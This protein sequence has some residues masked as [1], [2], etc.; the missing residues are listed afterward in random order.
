MNH[1]LL[2]LLFQFVL[3]PISWWLGAFFVIGY[4]LGREMAQAE[5]R[6]ISDF[7]GGKRANMPWWGSFEPRAWTEKGLL[8]WILPSVAVIACAF[9]AEYILLP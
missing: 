5:Y 7:Y 3:A 6:V 4:Y 9:F 1:I 8:H 2:A